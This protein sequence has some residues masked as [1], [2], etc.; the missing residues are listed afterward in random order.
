MAIYNC[1][2]SYFHHT[3][4]A[5]GFVLIDKGGNKTVLDRRREGAEPKANHYFDYDKCVCPFCTALEPEAFRLPRK[6]TYTHAYAYA[7]AYTS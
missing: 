5:S 7:C 4:Q 3:V 1:L 2:L 6:Y